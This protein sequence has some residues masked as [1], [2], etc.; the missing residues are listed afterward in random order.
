MLT[1]ITFTAG[2]RPAWLRACCKSVE[3][4]KFTGLQHAII[5]CEFKRDWTRLRLEALQFDEF[6]AFVDDDDIV[7]ENSLQLCL[8]AIKETGCGV[9]FTRQ[10]LIRG[11]EG[12][13]GQI[14]GAPPKTY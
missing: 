8:R 6:I 11:D 13:M 1:A 9:V 5:H 7:L 3:E 12:T 10:C 2:D 14:Y 4:Q